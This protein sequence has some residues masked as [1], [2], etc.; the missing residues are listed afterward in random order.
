MGTRYS[1]L[2][3][4]ARSSEQ[5]LREGAAGRVDLQQQPLT[6]RS[7][8]HIP[9]GVWSDAWQQQQQQQLNGKKFSFGLKDGFGARGSL[10]QS[11]FSLSSSSADFAHPVAFDV[12]FGDLRLDSVCGAA[13][14]P[15][16]SALLNF[17]E[18]A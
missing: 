2:S 9:R 4:S 17:W 10:V 5:K 18:L 12:H 15:L 1:V 13:Q 14:E 3:P 8:P 6:H 7:R 16:K 11:A